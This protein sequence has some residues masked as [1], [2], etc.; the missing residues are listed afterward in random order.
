MVNPS[1]ILYYLESIRSGWMPPFDTPTIANYLRIFGPGPRTLWLQ[2]IPSIIGLVWF[3]Y[4]W[5]YNHKSWRWE[6]EI[7]I[8]LLVSIIVSPFAW[9]Y[10]YVVLI[11]AIVQASIWLTHGNKRTLTIFLVII[12][13]LIGVINLVMHTKMSD[14]W[15]VWLA[16]AILIWYL[17]IRWQYSNQNNQ[18]LILTSD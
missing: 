11:P 14:Y 6:T 16:P 2:F 17:L 8:L 9:T 12:F 3:I 18:E 10:D 1:I 15:F 4:H 7:P 13:I 5:V